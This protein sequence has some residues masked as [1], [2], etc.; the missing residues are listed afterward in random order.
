[1][2]H[3]STMVEAAVSA[4]AGFAVG[5]WG[6]PK[7]HA[8]SPLYTP[9]TYSDTDDSHDGH[10]S[11]MRWKGASE[12]IQRNPPESG[13][14]QSGGHKGPRNRVGGQLLDNGLS[15]ALHGP[16]EAEAGLFDSDAELGEFH[17]GLARIARLDPAF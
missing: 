5:Y 1:M 2:D 12:R 13:P 10:E 8:S 6:A 16:G 3:T 15:S 9:D 4:A 7:P 17:T 14:G 11:G